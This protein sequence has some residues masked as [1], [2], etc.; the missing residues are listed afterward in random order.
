MNQAEAMRAM[1]RIASHT[2]AAGEMVDIGTLQRAAKQAAATALVTAQR[3][4]HSVGIRVME[5]A[6]GVRITVTGP[7]AHRYRAIVNA[8]LERLAPTT[9]AEVSS[10]IVRKIR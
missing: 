10:Q 1:N 3:A 2:A 4:G 6:N 9:S 7:K 8:E 5:R